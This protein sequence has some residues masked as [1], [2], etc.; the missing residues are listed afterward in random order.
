[1]FLK[2]VNDSSDGL[3]VICEMLIRF[4]MRV[5]PTICSLILLRTSWLDLTHMGIKERDCSCAN[6]GKCAW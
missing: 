1:M 4:L 3:C 6:T 2:I 5:L